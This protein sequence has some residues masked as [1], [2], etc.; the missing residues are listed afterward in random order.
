M[1]RISRF[2]GS[3]HQLRLLLLAV[4]LLANTPTQ[5][6]LPPVPDSLKALVRAAPAGSVA[7]G[8]ALLRVAAAYRAAADSAGVFAYAALASTEARARLDGET[9][10]RALTVRAEYRCQADE[11]QRAL[12]L[13]QRAERLLGPTGAPDAR[14]AVHYY[15]GWA[16]NGLG[17]KAEAFGHYRRAYALYGQVRNRHQQAEVLSDVGV[18]Y[19]DHGR[20]DSAAAYLYPALRW[21]RRLHSGPAYESTGLSN[22]G[23]LFDMQ[24]RKAEAAAFTRQSLALD[25][26][27]H[28][29]VAYVQGLENLAG[30]VADRDSLRPALH[31][32]RR[33]L[34]LYRRLGLT[35]QLAIPYTKLADLF[36]RLGLPDSVEYYHTLA[37]RRL[38]AQR[39]APTEV[40]RSMA[41]LAQFYLTQNRLTEARHWAT[42]ALSRTDTLIPGDGAKALQT[43]HRVAARQT[44][45]R[46]AY[47]YAL[48]EQRTQLAAAAAEADQVSENLRA[49]YG[50]TEAEAQLRRLQAAQQAEARR[51]QRQTQGLAAT[52]ALLAL[53]L[54]GG[55]WRRRRARQ[56]R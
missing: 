42:E 50:T 3:A 53:L 16:H 47:R 28:D 56:V 10:A 23:I 30:I 40:A 20:L 11:L 37:I 17:H 45:Y 19:L 39:S 7:R 25:A 48:R 49:R 43:L 2:F 14:A 13:L 24:H 4:W 1:T 51:H 22:L 9:E 38:L 29:S 6:A 36:G 8:R 44:D 33:A 46:A 32:Y 21:H 27:I 12:L 54:V 55:W 34:G 26:S 31:L 18:W 15:Q 41:S 5:A 35:G 52:A